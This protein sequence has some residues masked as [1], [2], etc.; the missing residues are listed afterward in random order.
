MRL[1]K[2]LEFIQPP[3]GHKV[4]R[5]EPVNTPGG[6]PKVKSKEHTDIVKWQKHAKDLGYSV[7]QSDT[8]LTALDK[9]G[10][11]MGF[12]DKKKGVGNIN[13]MME[14]IVEASSDPSPEQKFGTRHAHQQRIAHY[15]GQKADKC[16][17]DAKTPAG[18]ETAAKAHELALEHFDDL[19]KEG[20][21]KATHHRN[22]AKSH[23]TKGKE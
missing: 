11:K 14:S 18:H 6:A 17:K 3:Q 20:E 9:K 2:I 10:K 16:T 1:A 8:N 21:E 19:G 23:R 7:H 4:K 12:W 13:A 5:N 15:Y 22:Q